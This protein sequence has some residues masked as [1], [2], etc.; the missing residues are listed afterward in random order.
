MLHE[1][2]AP[3]AAAVCSAQAPNPDPRLAMDQGVRRDAPPPAGPLKPAAESG[4]VLSTALGAALAALLVVLLAQFPSGSGE[5]RPAPPPAGLRTLE[6]LDCHFLIARARAEGWRNATLMPQPEWNGSPLAVVV[7]SPADALVVLHH[8]GRVD[9][10]SLL[11]ARMHD[12]RF[13]A[14]VGSVFRPLARSGKPI[15]AWISPS[16]WEHWTATLTANDPTALQRQDGVRSAFRIGIFS[17]SVL[18]IITA[19]I[20][21]VVSRSRLFRAYGLTTA[22]ISL[23]VAEITSVAGYPQRWLV[24]AEWSASLSVALI[25][26]TLAFALRAL[27]NECNARIRWPHLDA[28]L[29]GALLAALPCALLIALAPAVWLPA[30]SRAVEAT[31]ALG[32]LLALGMALATLRQSPRTGSGVFIACLPLALVS[33]SSSWDPALLSGVRA[34]ATAASVVWLWFITLLLAAG[35]IGQA[36]D[37][38]SRMSRLAFSDALTGLPNRR[39]ALDYL[40]R[41]LARRAAGGGGLALAALDLD[42][43]K[44]INDEHGHA[45]GNLALRLF[46]ETLQR[47]RRQS[48]LVARIGGEEF[49]LALPDADSAQLQ[50]VLKTVRSDLQ[51]AETVARLGFPLR[52]SAGVVTLGEDESLAEL[53]ENADRQ[54]YAAKRAGRNQDAL[55]GPVAA[56]VDQADLRT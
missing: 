10:G 36:H 42:H 55:R 24:P 4:R 35:R 11:D 23:W 54:L 31:M 56:T 28:A 40:Q 50:R 26:L 49:L 52:F 53:L 38:L 2:A 9:C 20:A 14:G 22:M 41:Q 18:L 48:D 34:E 1:G 6:A 29:R 15:E 51:S 45:R 27:G 25:P 5:L 39:G 46:A 33:G 13:N 7:W 21:S 44:Q 16:A 17:A 12:S 32:M 30:L 43:F 8:S 47:A 37:T 19:V 3:R